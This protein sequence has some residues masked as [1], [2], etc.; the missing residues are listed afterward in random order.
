MAPTALTVT[1]LLKTLDEEDYKMAVS[2]IQFLAESRKKAKEKEI[3][4]LMNEFRNHLNG[5]Q[6]WDSEEEMLKDMAQFR[7][8]RMKL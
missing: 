8:E 4:S 5:D 7:R 1:N 3:S 6:G 2:Y